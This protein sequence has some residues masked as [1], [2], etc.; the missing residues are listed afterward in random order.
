MANIN[1]QELKDAVLK[2]LQE[3]LDGLRQDLREEIEGPAQA[4]ATRTIELGTRAAAGDQLAFENLQ[5]MR[6]Q[7]LLL[8]GGTASRELDR[9][10]ATLKTIVIIGV[11]T[12]VAAAAGI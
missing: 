10:L 12:L 4:L 7:A 1:A 9:A 3:H 5:D 11:R 2:V 6:A 8:A